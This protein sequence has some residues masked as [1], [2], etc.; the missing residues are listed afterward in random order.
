MSERPDICLV[1]QPG[2]SSALGCYIHDWYTEHQYRVHPVNCRAAFWPRAW[3]ALVSF[4]PHRETWYRRR[5][6]VGMFS[7]SAWDRHT[8]LNGKLLDKV[9][10]PGSKILQVS[11][12]Y[13]PHP[14]YRDIEYYVFINYN[15]RLSRCDGFTPWRPKPSEEE[16]FIEREDLLFRHAA[17]VFTA[18]EFLRQN[19]IQEAGVRPD[20]VTTVG[21]GVNP[22]YLQQP[23][24]PFADGFTYRLLFVGWD[25]GLKGGR[26]LLQAF[27]MIRAQ[28][29]QV[30]LH[31]V[32]PDEAQKAAQ[33][34]LADTPGVRWFFREKVQVAHYRSADL[35]VLPSL[36]D[37]YGFVFL[38]AMSQGLP[39]VGA[40]INGMP[41]IIEHGRSG[42]VV[43]R[44]NPEALAG[45]ICAYYADPA[46]KRRLAEAAYRR[47]CERFTWDIVLNKV[48]A[49]MRA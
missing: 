2:S 46:N 48:N 28:Y 33:G 14:N 36:R 44:H 1:Y 9:R 26:D 21:N 12:E 10:R 37:S 34:A 49:I 5:W 16:A 43:P 19:L 29:P 8:R 31:I 45:T 25:F 20:R 24:P 6:E 18:G 42:Y 4:H 47:L 32:G 35:F 22:R 23:P 13:F 3:P 40:D 27:P 15:A 7:P 38:E 30:E 41:E 17:H 39:C 11:K